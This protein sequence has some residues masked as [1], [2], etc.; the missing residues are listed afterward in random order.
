MLK[1]A[2]AR[3]LRL[4]FSSAKIAALRFHRL[5]QTNKQT[6]QGKL[7]YIAQ[8]GVKVSTAVISSRQSPPSLPRL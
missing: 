6:R 8:Q 3:I 1:A 7:S 5:K 2:S 4:R